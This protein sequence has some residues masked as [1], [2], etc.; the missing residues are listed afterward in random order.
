MMEQL[1]QYSSM[2]I[3]SCPICMT[4]CEKS[5]IV[6][7]K[8][9]F[10]CDGCLLKM[11][12]MEDKKCP[13]CRGDILLEP[14]RNLW[15]QDTIDA[16]KKE[17]TSMFPFRIHDSVDV[18]SEGHWEHGK[19][20]DVVIEKAA[21]L[22]ELDG[23]SKVV[24]RFSEVLSRLRPA[25]TMTPDWR[26][27]EYIVGHPFLEVLL[28]KENYKGLEACEE[29]FCLH[30]TIWVPC[31]VVYYCKKSHYIL[32]VF[33]QEISEMSDSKWYHIHSK[34]IRLRR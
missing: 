18:E 7:N 25:F 32:C 3:P 21:Y 14:I 8:G 26:H 9:H 20:T 2:V 27:E 19:I 4:M 29:M 11:Q 12:P 1:H 33:Q 31:V 34:G 17:M 15:A 22:C 10:A 13:L 28:C 30:E 5:F 16:I 23:E 24:V 6:C